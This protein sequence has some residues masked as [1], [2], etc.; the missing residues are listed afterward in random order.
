MAIFFL[1]IL[2]LIT[3]TFS[4]LSDWTVAFPFCQAQYS[5]ASCIWGKN[6]VFK[7]KNKNKNQGDSVEDSHS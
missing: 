5:E 4:T 6:S 1:I 3:H 7:N 2:I